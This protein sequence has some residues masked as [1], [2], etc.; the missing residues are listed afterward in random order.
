MFLIVLL[1]YA[2]FKLL[3]ERYKNRS[4]YYKFKYGDYLKA[5]QVLVYNQPF[6][7]HFIEKTKPHTPHP[8][9]FDPPPSPTPLLILFYLM[10]QH[11]V[12]Q[13]R[14]FIQD[15]RVQCIEYTSRIYI[16]KMYTQISLH[17]LLLL[18]SKIVESLQCILKFI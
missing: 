18:V 10:L 17:T 1:L 8:T 9:Y 16:L 5:K 14:P 6:S 3:F 11:P 12:Y 13:G 2:K 7:F 15:P 4:Q